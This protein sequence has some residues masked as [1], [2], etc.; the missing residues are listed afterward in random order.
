MMMRII[1]GKYQRQEVYAPKGWDTRPTSAKLREAVFN[2]LQQRIAEVKFLDL[3]AGSGGMGF[4]A[5]SRGAER[6]V[7]IEKR[8]ECVRCLRKTAQKLEAKES[9]LIYRDDVFRRL[10]KMNDQAE[11]F[12]V[13]YV[14][15]PYG[16]QESQRVLEW[17]DQNMILAQDGIL[18]IEEAQ[19]IELGIDN[20]T[21]LKVQ[22][23]R[24]FGRSKLWIF[25]R[26]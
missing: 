26:L 5:L 7:F 9:V 24:R 20:L 22:S 6:V 23:T 13:I 14:D 16:G 8:P 25:Q 1:S 18:M 17:I 10:E 19:E 2:I 3:F 21:G 11:V 12:D 15:P 4:E